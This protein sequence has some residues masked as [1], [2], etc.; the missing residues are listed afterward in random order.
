MRILLV[1][2]EKIEREGI[3]FLINKFNMPLIVEEASNGKKA[4]EYIEKENNVDILLTDVKM[5]HMDGLELAKKVNLFNPNIVIII[6]SAY[7]EF[8]YA[9]KACQANAVNYLLKPIEL[10]EF[11]DVMNHVMD[12]CEKRKQQELLK[13][14][15]KKLWLF[16]LI[17]TKDAIFEIADILHYK[18][19]I[20]LENKNMC[21]ISIETC[22]NYFEQNGEEFEIIV[23][24]NIGQNFEIINLYPNLSY[25]LLYSSENIDMEEIENSIRKIYSRLCFDK[26]EKFSIIV[27]TKFLGIK[28]FRNKLQE[29][30]NILKDTFSY[31]SG[32]IY[33]SKT[34]VKSA[35]IMEEQFQLKESV[36]K[37]I[38]DKNIIALKEQLFLYLK[39]LEDEKSSS[40]FFAKYLILDIVKA[41]YQEFGTYNETMIVNTANDIMNS[42]DL[43]K[44]S[45]VLIKILEEIVEI[46][47]EILPDTS[48]A[49]V[50][51]KKIVKNEYMNDIGL[52]EIA[53]KVC[54]TS[55][56]V[57]FIFKKETGNTLIKYL[58]DYRMKQ[59]KELLENSNMKIVDI[60]KA[61]GYSNQSYFN[62]LFKNYYGMT[63]KQY[64]EQ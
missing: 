3:K 34:D 46:D 59:A 9:K 28:N 7:S 54:L 26:K 23:R 47:K 5:P 17:N 33:T 56:Y 53:D 12:I 24:S 19:D 42:N 35:G 20:N 58:T 10:D 44:V 21:F 13:E 57:S 63:P 61:C 45:E 49:I 36:M 2:D 27:G 32:I 11:Q 60:G 6:F 62:K 43:K 50:E 30:E 1:D 55:S 4:W 8:D 14:S 16:R 64:R 38:K 51:I 37:S 39:R 31:F 18:Y 15:D 25:V 29:L 40:A 48:L 41:I 52:E 22:G